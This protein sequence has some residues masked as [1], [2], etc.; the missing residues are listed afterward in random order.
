MTTE[1]K[2]QAK[3]RIL[4]EES[5]DEFNRLVKRGKAPDLSNQN[6]SDLDLRPFDLS[7]VNL[8]GSYLR[9]ANLSGMDLSN[10]DLR[11]ASIK[12]AQISGCLFPDNLPAGEISLSHAF[13]TRMRAS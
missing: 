9:R 2:R 10:A 3:P 6:L 4:L 12:N 1:I 11:G 13:G 7:A 8:S 5:A